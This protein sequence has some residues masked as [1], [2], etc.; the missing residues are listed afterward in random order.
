MTT[1]HMHATASAF[2]VSLIAIVGF[3][4]PS[5]ASAQDLA[6]LRLALAKVTATREGTAFVVWTDG[7]TAYLITAAHVI[8]GED[9]QVAFFSDLDR[10]LQATTLGLDTANDFAVLRVDDPPPGV[11]ALSFELSREPRVGETVN[12]IGF[13]RRSRDA[14]VRRGVLSGHRGSSLVVDVGVGEGDS[15]GPLIQNSKVVGVVTQEENPLAYGVP[16]AI[17]LLALQGWNIAPFREAQKLSDVPSVV[18]VVDVVDGEASG[19]P[20]PFSITTRPRKGK[21]LL[22]NIQQRAPLHQRVESFVEVLGSEFEKVAR[23]QECIG[24]VTPD[25]LFKKEQRRREVAYLFAQSEAASHSEVAREISL[26]LSIRQD[27]KREQVRFMAVVEVA[28]DSEYEEAQVAM[29]LWGVGS[30]DWLEDSFLRFGGNRL[31]SSG[32]G[33]Q[34][35]KMVEKICIAMQHDSDELFAISDAK[36]IDQSAMIKS[37]AVG[38]LKR[39]D[40]VE[41]LDEE[42]HGGSYYHIKLKSGEEG[43]VAESAVGKI[44]DI[45]ERPLKAGEHG[46]IKVDELVGVWVREIVTSGNLGVERR[47]VSVMSFLSTGERYNGQS[48]AFKRRGGRLVP[49]GAT[50]ITWDIDDEGR[51]IAIELWTDITEKGHRMKWNVSWVVRRWV[52][53]NGVLDLE[54]LFE[55]ISRSVITFYR[56]ASAGAGELQEFCEK[57]RIETFEK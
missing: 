15:G 5:G 19:E 22:I 7:K 49:D 12:L 52:A 53:L 39:W 41:L 11:T 3:M 50:P 2:L 17:V 34:I 31:G 25:R 36:V 35:E 9:V 42:I 29:K 55:D 13:P 43:Y 38:I 32:L 23:S 30:S 40:R 1:R 20:E 54:L 24:F 6:A 26:P 27:L 28:D 4:I 45:L 44:S 33:R 56:C 21:I 18:D 47:S 51:I 57:N 14:L 8:E 37:N 48:L 10:R 46:R 16:S